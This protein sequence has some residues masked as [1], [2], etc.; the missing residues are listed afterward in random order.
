MSAF[1]KGMLL[2]SL[3][4]GGLVLILLLLRSA[5]AGKLSARLLHGLWLVVAV[6]LLLFM[7]L[8]APSSAWN[9]APA[10][11]KQLWQAE[12]T[13]LGFISELPAADNVQAE[14]PIAEAA[15]VTK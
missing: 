3:S 14:R 5:F 1:L 7:P 12:E 10:P 11:V 9:L 8:P 15:P 6:R 4:G 2:S 13:G